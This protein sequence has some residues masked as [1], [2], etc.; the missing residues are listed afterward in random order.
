MGLKELSYLNL[1]VDQK[2]FFKE[3]CPIQSNSIKNIIMKHVTKYSKQKP[4]YVIYDKH[5][6]KSIDYSYHMVGYFKYS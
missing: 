6:D 2:K 5:N 3:K 1:T 4:I